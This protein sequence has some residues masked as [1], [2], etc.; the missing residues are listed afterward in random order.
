MQCHF[1]RDTHDD[2]QF[3]KCNRTLTHQM[4]ERRSIT[5]VECNELV[6]DSAT[7]LW[8]PIEG[9]YYGLQSYS[10]YNCMKHFCY[11]CTPRGNRLKSCDNCE[12]EYCQECMPVERCDVCESDCCK[13][14][15][16]MVECGECGNKCC[17]NDCIA[18]CG[19]LQC[20][21]KVCNSLPLRENVISVP[22]F[23]VAAVGRS[24]GV[25]N[26]GELLWLR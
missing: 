3:D 20:N 21:E 26:V 16:S 17:S 23:F 6:E 19:R 22:F 1:L 25:R 7:L 11:N 12:K 24:T 15:K 4:F 18:K 14:C 8:F 5:C 9:H 2:F 13:Q 10:C